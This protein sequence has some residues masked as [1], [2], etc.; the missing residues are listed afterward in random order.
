M[1]S[2]D[3]SDAFISSSPSSSSSMKRAIIKLALWAGLGI[4]L[5]ILISLVGY[6][7]HLTKKLLNEQGKVVINPESETDSEFKDDILNWMDFSADPCT[8][9]YQY[10]CGG[11]INKAVLP[12]GVDMY[13]PIFSEV[14][15]DNYIV[16]NEIVN[17]QWPLVNDLYSSCMISDSQL[18]QDSLQ[19]LTKILTNVQNLNSTSFSDLFPM[20]ASLHRMGVQAFF[21]P[22]QQQNIFQSNSLIY[23]LVY[24]AT[25]PMDLTD[26][27]TI[28]L[29]AAEILSS[30]KVF[31]PSFSS[32]R[33]L[34]VAQLEASI[35][36][37]FVEPETYD[38]YL[39]NMTWAEFLTLTGVD[40]NFY[41][42]AIG[43]NLQPNDT[44]I[45]APPSYFRNIT[46]FY[47]GASL[48]TIVDYLSWRVLFSYQYQFPV[49]SSSLVGLEK[50]SEIENKIKENSNSKKQKF[51]DST[52]KK[53]SKKNFV[54]PEILKTHIGATSDFTPKQLDCITA[55]DTMLGDFLGL[56]FTM[57]TLDDQVVDDIRTVTGGIQNSFKNNLASLQWI[58]D[59]SRVAA[60]YKL[61]NIIPVI[62]HPNRL[63]RYRGLLLDPNHFVSNIMAIY[64]R[65]FD[66]NLEYI[67]TPYD[68]SQG[69]FPATIVNAFYNPEANT[70]NFPAGILE[71]PMFSSSFP[72]VMQY[73]RMGYVIGHETTHGFDNNGRLWNAEGVYQPIMDDES[74]A[75]FNTRAQC[76]VDQYNKFQPVPG[77]FVDGEQ[78]LGENIA[79]LGG[80]KNAFQA[81]KAWV[82][83]NGTATMA[84]SA[85]SPILSQLT[86]EQSFFVVMAQT[87]CTKASTKGLLSQLKTDVHSPSQ[88]RVNGPLS[89]LPDF[90]QA[91]KCPA[92][93]PMNP[94]SKCVLW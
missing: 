49:F 2:E 8:D 68:R 46:Q 70:I 38:E 59:V 88:Y 17:D 47:T 36:N 85:K 55:V 79:D 50:N 31:I 65:V 12:K 7:I 35:N 58:D 75:E 27:R 18:N 60:N 33:A 48:Q 92:N 40:Y 37:A 93:S 77:H 89:N 6:E 4:F 76:I 80:V 83:A 29:V 19:T 64:Q 72:K 62:G 82:Q 66:D 51:V 63:D 81:Y 94:S 41:T 30:M 57:K 52:F 39:V 90:S 16:L 21:T 61:E 42:S 25:F 45:A 53:N 11:F 24:D 86:N 44:V 69:E 26:P 73:A 5:I 23:F 91:F 22:T 84:L 3:S 78:T 43:L 71:S 56:I 10:S 14:Q 20:L 13:I 15:Y 32:S 1:Y 28:T 87:W 74:S 9:F 34:K 54:D 67:G